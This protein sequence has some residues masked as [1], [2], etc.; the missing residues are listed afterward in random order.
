MTMRALPQPRSRRAR[1]F[2][3]CAVLVGLTLMATTGAL[4]D[5]GNR[6][7]AIVFRPVQDSVG[8][9]FLHQNGASPRKH[10]IETMGSGGGFIDFDNDGFLDVYLVQGA[11]LDESGKPTG[12]GGRLFH[13][14]GGRRF[15]DVTEGSGIRTTDWYGMGVAV[16]DFDNDGW[17]DLFLTGYPR[18]YLFRNLGTG[19]FADVSTGAGVSGGGW[20]TSAAF[21]DYDNDGWLDLY[22]C[23]YVD[24]DPLTEPSCGAE[25]EG[26]KSYCLPDAF[27]GISG[28]LFRNSG[29]QFKEVTRETGVY[30]PEA[31]SLGVTISDFDNDGNQD[32]FVANDRVR[33]FLF[34]NEGAGRF[35]ERGE[36]AGVAYSSDGQVRAGMGVDFADADNDGQPDVLVTNFETEGA[37]LFRN[38]NGL[39]EDV[40]MFS[41]LGPRSFLH[42]GFGA[43]LVD[44][45]GDGWR[46]IFLVNGHVLDNIALYK[47]GVSYLDKKQVFRHLGGHK[48]VYLESALTSSPAAVGRGAAFGDY[49]N[50][51]KVDVLVTNNGGA[52]ELL[53]NESPGRNRWMAFKLVGTQSNRDA[54][55]A[56][57]EL[58]AG[59][60]RYRAE[61][62]SSGSYLSSH[63]LRV[64]VGLGT[65]ERVEQVLIHWPSGLTEQLTD[66]KPNRILRVVEGA[67]P[68]AKEKPQSQP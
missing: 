32:L 68:S 26:W 22:V 30:R 65:N 15:E 38:L 1:F 60:L 50:D 55:G 6:S 23:R 39:F 12:T 16:A 58:R 53:R 19:R 56:R 52:A 37:A 36:L 8:L 17:Q 64:Y 63:D 33:N 18:N 11:R 20:S 66:L 13:N 43:K 47:D 28:L 62:A 25:K 57:L 31:K 5:E 10:M 9:T 59:G 3:G 34:R 40:A 46:D 41:E 29:G 48:F 54:I 44:L 61:V 49:D 7:P 45:D 42:V 2:S 67:S 4:P 14:L 51:G 21:F 24:Y 35:L 27:K